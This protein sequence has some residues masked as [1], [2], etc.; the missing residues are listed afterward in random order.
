MRGCCYCSPIA[1]VSLVGV[2]ESDERTGVGEGH[3][4]GMR[5]MRISA[6]AT[7]VR[8][9]R[10]PL[11]ANDPKHI[12]EVP[13]TVGRQDHVSVIRRS[14]LNVTA[15]LHRVRDLS[16]L[17]HGISQGEGERVAPLQTSRALSLPWSVS[18][19][20]GPAV[21]DDPRHRRGKECQSYI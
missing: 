16:F 14:G 21:K 9:V 5:S 11:E 17:A 7:P 19:R 8:Q 10:P 3:A 2:K 12:V 13:A 18:A 6:R 20:P 15:M 4:L 1:V